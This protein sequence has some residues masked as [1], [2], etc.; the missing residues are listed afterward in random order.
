MMRA[1]LLR[2]I[3]QGITALSAVV[4]AYATLRPNVTAELGSDSLLHFMLFFPLGAGGALWMAQLPP[5][6]QKRARLGILLLILFF[7][8]ATELMQ[9]PIEGRSASLS[10]FFADAAGGGLGL[11]VGGWMAAR[12]RR[13][14]V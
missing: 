9:I 11:L 8:A 7:G 6:L 1:E 12:A 3:G 2:K 14:G 4:I 10:D 5:L 13:N